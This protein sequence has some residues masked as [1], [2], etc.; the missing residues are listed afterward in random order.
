MGGKYFLME[1]L[2]GQ[3]VSSFVLGRNKALGCFCQQEWSRSDLQF[4]EKSQSRICWHRLGQFRETLR[5]R[6]WTASARKLL[7]WLREEHRMT[8]SEATVT[9]LSTGPG[10][11]DGKPA[12]YQLDGLSFLS[13]QRVMELCAHRLSSLVQQSRTVMRMVQ[14]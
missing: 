12:S 9:D 1:T 7:G 5:S 8:R 6:L 11:G 3:Q 4:L 14:K 10:L 2:A 13:C